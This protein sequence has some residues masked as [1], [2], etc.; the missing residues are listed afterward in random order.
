MIHSSKHPSSYLAFFVLTFSLIL[1][2]LLPGT[3]SSANPDSVRSNPP[4]G[5]TA[6]EWTGIQTGIREAEYQ[7]IWHDP[8]H[9]FHAPNRAQGFDLAL[10]GDELQV[11]VSP[12]GPAGQL[13]LVLTGYGSPNTMQS[14]GQP[15]IS[16][17]KDRIFTEWG[18]LNR[19]G[20]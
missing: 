4:N 3:T 11:S 8:T 20:L 14:P 7:F 9:A 12:P 2:V 19:A 5:L 10:N 13:S 16:V 15:T 17:Q 18:L 6:F 1:L